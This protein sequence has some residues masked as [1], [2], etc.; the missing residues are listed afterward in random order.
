MMKYHVEV[1]SP[2]VVVADD[3]SRVVYSNQIGGYSCRDFSMTGFAVPLEAGK[4]VKEVVAE[5]YPG[6]TFMDEGRVF[7]TWIPKDF[8]EGMNEIFVDDASKYK[9]HCYEGI[10]E[11]TADKVDEV[12]ARYDYEIYHRDKDDKLV[13]ETVEYVRVDRDALSKAMEAMI[14]VKIMLAMVS[15][16]ESLDNFETRHGILTWHNSD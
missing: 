4:F 16:P 12:L 9:G 6:T 1:D 15:E 2:G 3:G 11:D 7:W 14:P 8:T 10:G 5:D 13:S